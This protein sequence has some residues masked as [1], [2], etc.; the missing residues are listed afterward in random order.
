MA[1]RRRY[2]RRS[3][4]LPV[5]LSIA[6]IV[7]LTWWF[8]SD[9][10]T[11]VEPPEQVA[12]GPSVPLTS[13]RPKVASA[14]QPRPDVKE[15]GANPLPPKRT[16]GPEPNA[17]QANAL[18]RAGEQALA[19]DDLISARTHFTE[20]VAQGPAA[21]EL[22]RIRAEL[23]RIGNDTVFSSR[24]FEGDP[25]VTR[26]TIQTGDT[27]G[28]IAKAHK[29]S[30]DLLA[31]INGLRNANLIRAGQS[32]KVVKG[33]FSAV[34]H[35]SD[36]SMDV[37]LGNTLAKHFKVGLGIDDS[38][39]T[40]MWRVGTKLTNPT[41]YPPR[42]GD[43]IDAD[44]PKNPLGERW[45]ALVGIDGAAAGAQRYGIHGTIEPE[46]IGRAM[47]M[48]CIRMY[49]ED[50]AALYTYLVEKHSTVKVVK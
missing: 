22:R 17:D 1:R 2:R 39:P 19:R 24:I 15:K 28:K 5:L 34:V 37:Y 46:S 10:K 33:P 3:P 48:G 30:P 7:V 47:S 13:N 32:L 20:A 40:G 14:T 44:D 6:A 16:T 45:I 21:A 9:S 38:T 36:Y 8:S 49:N 4:V 29:I 42:G 25:L 26:Y 23:T 35:K 43:L 11:A 18:I 27:L 31:N 50:V 41:Y 12:V